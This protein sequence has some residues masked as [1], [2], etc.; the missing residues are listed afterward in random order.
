MRCVKCLVGFCRANFRYC[1][2]LQTKEMLHK[3][4]VRQSSKF[5]DRNPWFVLKACWPGNHGQ[6]VELRN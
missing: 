1:V 6:F 4:L 3:A 5:A 2:V